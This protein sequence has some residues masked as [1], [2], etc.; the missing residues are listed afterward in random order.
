MIKKSAIA[1]ASLLLINCASSGKISPLEL[2][3]TYGGASAVKL[4][5]YSLK[6]EIIHLLNIFNN[7]IKIDEV[8][9]LWTYLQFKSSHKNYSSAVPN[10]DNLITFKR[11]LNEKNLNVA[12]VSKATFESLFALSRLPVAIYIVSLDFNKEIASG[13][14][15]TNLNNVPAELGSKL[16]LSLI[17]SAGRIESGIS[18]NTTSHFNFSGISKDFLMVQ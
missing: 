2:V 16:S 10:K 17:K 18:F 15:I 1:L 11:L 8:N 13:I 4:D 3:K 14:K 12:K 9:Q 6:D 5:E 7:P